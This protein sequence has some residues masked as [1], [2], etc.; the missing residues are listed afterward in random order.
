MTFKIPPEWRGPYGPRDPLAGEPPRTP[1]SQDNPAP[2]AAD[3][4]SDRVRVAEHTRS[5]PGPGQP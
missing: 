5:R 3:Q 4:N 2:P 1:E